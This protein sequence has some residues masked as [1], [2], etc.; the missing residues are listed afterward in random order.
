MRTR[1]QISIYIL[2]AMTL[3]ILMIG[4]T[5][6]HAQDVRPAAKKK[7]LSIP[8]AAFTEEQWVE[9]W[10]ISR[11]G[12]LLRSFPG[13]VSQGVGH[14]HAAVILPQ[15]AKI[16]QVKMVSK[17]SDIPGITLKLMRHTVSGSQAVDTQLAIVTNPSFS[18]A[19]FLTHGLM[20]ATPHKV[21]NNGACYSLYLYLPDAEGNDVA[22]HHAEII[23]TGKW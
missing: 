18:S 2:M 10:N 16:L 8:A 14:F 9:D 20:L 17:N 23:Y 12:G 19:N 22:F 13:N 5:V 6:V 3:S 21:D 4:A 15:K 1:K 11:E 7:V